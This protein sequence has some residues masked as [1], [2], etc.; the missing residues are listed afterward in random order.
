MLMLEESSTSIA[1]GDDGCA[2]GGGAV[3]AGNAG[4]AITRCFVLWRAVPNFFF[5]F[6]LRDSFPAK[7]DQFNCQREKSKREK[8]DQK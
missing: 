3:V 2:G 6:R 1:A 5:R 4:R 7:Q 8:K